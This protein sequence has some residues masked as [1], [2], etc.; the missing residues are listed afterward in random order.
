MKYRGTNFLRRALRTLA[1]AATAAGG[2]SACTHNDGGLSPLV[3]EIFNFSPNFS[4]VRINAP[5]ELTFSAPVDPASVNP[6][7]IRIFTTTTTT[8]QP[9]PGAPAIGVFL[10]SGNVVRFLPKVPKEADL[11]DAGLRIGFRYAIQ[12]PAAPDVIATVLTTEGKPVEVS[13]SEEFTTLNQTILPA[14]GDITAEPNLPSLHQ[15]F[16]DEGIQNGNDPCVRA[17][18]PSPDNPSGVPGAEPDSPQV[19]FSDPAEGESGFGTITGIQPGLGTAFVRMDPITL[20]FSEPIGPWRIRPQDISIRNTNLG[21][22][23]FDLFLSFRQD[24]TESILQVTVFDSES[25]FDKASVPQGRY[26]LSLDNFSD[27]AGNPLVNSN[28]C[29]ADGTF[30]LTFSTVSSP[31][32]PTDIILAFN[33][34][35]GDGHVDVGGLDTGTNDPNEFP[36][37]SAAIGGSTPV[38]LG[39]MA[40]D[41]VA[42]PSPSA[43]TSNANWGSVAYWTGCEMRFDNGFDL[44]APGM[45]RPI[46]NSLRLRGGAVGGSTAIMAPIAGRA[47]GRSDTVNG[48]TT[49]SVAVT[50]PA[51]DI[52]KIDFTVTGAVTVRLFTGNAATGPILYHYRVV[53]ITEDAGGGQPVVT[54]GTGSIYPLLMFA[55]DSMTIIGATVQV[56][57]GNGD[58]GFNGS[59]DVVDTFGRNPG[60]AG[61]VGIAGGGSGGNGGCFQIGADIELLWGTNG[62]VPTNVFGTLDQLNEAA[63]GLVGMATGGGGLYDPDAGTDPDT[64]DEPVFQGG[65]GGGQGSS[66]IDGSDVCGDATA[67]CSHGVGGKQFGTGFDFTDSEYLASGGGGGGGGGAED[68]DGFGGQGGA[69]EADATDDGGGGGGAAGGFIGLFSGGNII[70][71]DIR[72]ASE[73]PADGEIEVDENG[74]PILDGD[75]NVI[76][77]SPPVLDRYTFS[78]IRAVGGRGGSTYNEVGGSPI[79]PGPGPT[80]DP[81]TAIGEGEAGGGGGGGGICIIAAGQIA[82]PAIEILPHGKAGGNSPAFEAGG[83]GSLNQAGNGG[84][85][86]FV[87]SDSDGISQAERPQE[88]GGTNLGFHVIPFINRDIDNDGAPDLDPNDPNDALKIRDFQEMTGSFGFSFLEWGDDAREV[89]YARSQ[90]VAEFFDTLSDSTSY[91]SVRV[92]SNIPRFGYEAN[93]VDSPDPTQRTIRIFLDVTKAK[94]GLPDLSG[95]DPVTGDLNL[96]SVGETL[97]IGL[98]YDRFTGDDEDNLGDPIGPQYESWFIIPADGP[99]LGKRYARVR[100]VYDLTTI[101]D[102]QTLLSSFAPPGAINLPIADDPDTPDPENTLG[103]TDTAPEGV[104]AVAEVRV[105][106]TVGG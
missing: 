96:N 56:D 93:P 45:D 3:V 98:F 5:L 77:L 1:I 64:G 43:V 39:G 104:P 97:E 80:P 49:G 102:A 40:I 33:D 81:T 75:G 7:S 41:T 90:I 13:F 105:T 59:N 34:G 6:D 14:P 10:V 91:D 23:T 63:A 61:G 100:I 31:T 52:G 67:L 89:S 72:S 83:R 73:D 60:G 70:L 48:T 21:G 58:F 99:T 24:R 2:L 65:G 85:G 69:G 19:V 18:P 106:F 62:A 87:M 28:T 32:L 50:M 16:I 103:N 44:L 17:I 78:Y 29:V 86:V 42:V 25:A 92:L 47:I 26:V 84:G 54:A 68:D 12:V 74:D 71:G 51:E 36:D 38:F 30:R 79:V 11:S 15:F 4:G 57:G 94:N 66:G 22:K 101:G 82:L 88:L 46:P 95:E 8:E 53:S 55:E 35:D 76:P 9:D 20:I 37:W 27:L